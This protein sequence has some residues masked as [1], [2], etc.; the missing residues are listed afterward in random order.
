MSV[1]LASSQRLI[2]GLTQSSIQISIVLEGEKQSEGA[3]SGS[4]E[5]M[6]VRVRVRVRV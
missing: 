3:Q 5:R 1:P 4:V 6:S 2:I